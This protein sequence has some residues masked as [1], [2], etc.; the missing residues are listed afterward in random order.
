[1]SGA[2][3]SS[4]RKSRARPRTLNGAADQVD[5]SAESAEAVLGSLLLDPAAWPQVADII[6]QSD[7]YR[8]DHQLIFGAIAALLGTG[9]QCDA[10]LVS[11][12]LE[13]VGSIEDAGGLAYLSQLA[14]ETALGEKAAALNVCTHA[15]MVRKYS[16]QRQLQAL[17][18]DISR[19]IDDKREPAQLIA[20]VYA[21]AESLGRRLPE[22]SAEKLPLEPVSKWAIRP[23]PGPRDFVITGLVPGRRVSSFLADGGLGKTTITMQ[24]GVHVAVNRAIY[25]LEVSGGRV[26]G[27]F[28]EDEADELDRKVRAA[29]DAEQI[30]LE[31]VD[32]FVAISREGMNN[33]L[34]WFEHDQL[35]LTPFYHQ[36]EATVA[37]FLPRL[38]IL[39]TLA[40]FFGGDY[41]STP[42]VRQ[43]IKTAL[44]RLCV[45]HGCA[46]L[47]VAHPSASGRSSG[48][49]DGFSTAWNNSVRSRLYLRRPK[50]EDT[51][52][53]QD[54]RV[55]EVRK[56]NY[57]P[58]GV[59]IPLIWRAGAF[60][61]DAE[62]VEE[63]PVARRAPKVDTRLAVAV[64]S[65]MRV[66]GADG[67]VVAFRPLYE[68][69]QAS[70]DLPKG[71][72]EVVRKPLQR[73]LKELESGS[74]IASCQVP[75]GYRLVPNPRDARDMPGDKLGISGTRGHR[76][77]GDTP[78]KGG[79]SPLSPAGVPSAVVPEGSR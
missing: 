57:G 75:R 43:F 18:V 8:H 15:E 44:G 1:M 45:R 62:P 16:V 65:C 19:G 17:S 68:A 38:V 77:N 74:L 20:R 27:I 55:L 12:E 35:M 22:A 34:C 63:A 41:L 37:A 53:A 78:Y 10:V 61:P 64:L 52:A 3:S 54:R 29:C 36:L 28:C 70:G 49:G 9:R 6:G 11:K 48:E 67:T 25:G 76:D 50:T 56:A 2:T 33:L 71:S 32:Q 40:D 39:D 51:D 72:Y 59:S 4:A 46:V 60:V 24:I 42:H 31:Q 5:Q 58:G 7:F 26:L 79:V 73:A 23:Q 69:L 14:R 13:R 30:E 21:I 47:L 66:R